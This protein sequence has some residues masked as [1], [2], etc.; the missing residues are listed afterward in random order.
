MGLVTQRGGG[1]VDGK[2]A[3]A[4]VRERLGARR[5]DDAGLVTVA[6]ASPVSE[7]IDRLAAAAEAAG[8]RVFARV[9]HAAG[10]ARPSLE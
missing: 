1:R 4:L 5:M 6:S 9:D 2:A 7:T 8:M 3:S 10:A